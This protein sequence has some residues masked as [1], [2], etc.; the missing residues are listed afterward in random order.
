MSASL[1]YLTTLQILQFLLGLA[2]SLFGL[3]LRVMWDLGLRPSLP[4]VGY[5]PVRGEAWSWW[6][7]PCHGSWAGSYFGL[8]VIVSYLVLF[9]RLYNEKYESPSPKRSS[10]G[11]TM[12][13]KS[14]P[15]AQVQSTGNG[16]LAASRRT[17]SMDMLSPASVGVAT[18]EDLYDAM[19]SAWLAHPLITT[20]KARWSSGSVQP[21][22]SPKEAMQKP[23]ATLHR[24]KFGTDADRL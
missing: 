5:P 8:A 21:E 12:F 24:R 2:A 14:K 23:E 1:Q 17:P 18:Q 9:M 4:V 7:A 16:A 10:G 3:F 11:E 15:V 6:S 19:R 13:V 22:E 20:E